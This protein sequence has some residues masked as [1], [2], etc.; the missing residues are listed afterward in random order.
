MKKTTLII[1][2]F[3][4]TILAQKENNSQSI[5]LPDFV[6]TG[7]QKIILPKTQKSEPDFI[8]LLSKDFFNPKLPDEEQISVKLND[9]KISEVKIDNK[10]QN[11]NG[12]LKLSAGLYTL[13][14][15]DFFYGNHIK[16]FTYSSHLF[17]LQEKQYLKHAG[18]SNYGG[19]LNG[20]YFVKQNA[21]TLPGLEIGFNGNYK[22]ENYNFFGSTIPK[23]IRKT[24]IADGKIYTK[25]TSHKNFQFGLTFNDN[26]YNQTNDT[27]GENIFGTDAFMQFKLM[28]MNFNLKSTY[29]NQ[30]I[31]KTKLHFGNTYYF[32][33]I[34][35]AS[36]NLFERINIKAGAYI[37][38][39]NKN[40]F[41]SPIAF[42][43]FK[44][45]NHLSVLGEFSPFAELKT[46]RNFD[47]RNRYFKLNNFVNSFV[48]N[49]INMKVALRYEYEQYFEISGGMG[50][51]S[52]NNDI[53]FEDNL[54]QGFFSVHKDDI[55]N[56]YVFLNAL[57]R[58]G[59]GGEFYGELKVQDIRASFDKKVPYA[60]TIVANLNYIYNFSSKF[61][62]KLK[63]EY[64][65]ATYTNIDNN[66]KIPRMVNLSLSAFYKL[67]KNF[68]FTFSLE[69]LL[70]NKYYYYQNYQAKP[71]DVFAGFE[72][73]W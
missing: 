64:H 28:N 51:L 63:F 52:S 56:T 1:L 23:L 48:E 39:S 21:K 43:S 38:E 26:Y 65:D 58:K 12:L 19:S 32:N 73:R 33:V 9:E 16:N 41:F 11:T 67:F 53:Y 66:I 8:P 2:F 54:S 25:Y 14:K 36:I 17:G 20:K 72:L 27:I 70:N 45:S 31:N 22:F 34:A 4:I 62:T 42:G 57:F 47:N 40:T 24:N 50:Y 15:V 55:K 46:L 3:S 10:F 7:K 61:G 29:K 30:T 60:P 69:N 5:E 6:I 49:K 68:N 13:P 35:T 71:L 37:A 59:P 44:L 18:I